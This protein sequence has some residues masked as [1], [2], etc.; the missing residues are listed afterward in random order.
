M[1]QLTELQSGNYFLSGKEKC[2]TEYMYDANDIEIVLA[3]DG[4]L[5]GQISYSS[6]DENDEVCQLEGTWE[7]SGRMEYYVTY[8]GLKFECIAAFRDGIMAGKFWIIDEN[9]STFEEASENVRGTF[10]Y[11]GLGVNDDSSI[12]SKYLL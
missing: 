4:T 2:E 3:D 10:R 5:T 7:K 8:A 1:V 9:A 11:I 6:C 12:L